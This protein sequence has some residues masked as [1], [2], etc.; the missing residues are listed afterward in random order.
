MFDELSDRMTTPTTA[1]PAWSPRT[2]TP[3]FGV[4]HGPKYHPTPDDHQQRWQQHFPGGME[5]PGELYQPASMRRA[6]IDPEPSSSY[7]ALPEDVQDFDVEDDMA[8]DI[9]STISVSIFDDGT[10]DGN[11]AGAASSSSLDRGTAEMQWLMDAPGVLDDL[12][13]DHTVVQQEQQE[14]TP[15]DGQGRN[16]NND[17]HQ[18]PWASDDAVMADLHIASMPSQEIC[19]DAL[20]V[21]CCDY[22]SAETSIPT[23]VCVPETDLD[24]NGSGEISTLT[25]V[26]VHARPE[27]NNDSG[28]DSGNGSVIGIPLQLAPPDYERNV[29]DVSAST[30]AVHSYL[31]PPE[32]TVVPVYMREDPPVMNFVTQPDY[33]QANNTFET[34]LPASMMENRR[35]KIAS[36]GRA[37]SDE[38]DTTLKSDCRELTAAVISKAASHVEALPGGRNEPSPVATSSSKMSIEAASCA[39]SMPEHAEE[40]AAGES[41]NNERLCLEQTK[42]DPA[43]EDEEMLEIPPLQQQERHQSPPQDCDNSTDCSHHPHQSSSTLKGSTPFEH[44]KPDPPGRFL[45]EEQTGNTF[46]GALSSMPVSMS[47]DDYSP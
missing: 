43:Q 38:E 16:A 18:Q 30:D 8:S 4:A 11:G 14:A 3:P 44:K 34:L 31:P 37:V 27:D 25:S 9:E 6:S 20:D 12:E 42:D 7:I 29:S 19:I 10:E 35:R 15:N 24:R 17:A 46:T 33:V 21:V 1:T 47:L 40:A 22:V 41:K 36:G 5:P 32:E 28:S 39:Q 13:H 45:L 26:A 2:N 23:A